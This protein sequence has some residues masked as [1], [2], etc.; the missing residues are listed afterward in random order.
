[1][2]HTPFAKLKSS[3][4]DFTFKQL[5]RSEIGRCHY[6]ANIHC[7]TCCTV[8]QEVDKV[9]KSPWLRSMN[10]IPLILGSHSCCMLVISWLRILKGLLEFLLQ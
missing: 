6:E 2:L 7:I 8:I 3:K 1:M 5:C 9:I 10:K 4:N